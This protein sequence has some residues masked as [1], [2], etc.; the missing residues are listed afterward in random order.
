MGFNAADVAAQGLEVVDGNAADRPAVPADADAVLIKVTINNAGANRYKSN[1]PATGGRQ[2]PAELRLMDPRTGQQ[3]TSWGAQD[4]CVYEPD[5]PTTAESPDGCLDSGLIFGGAFPWE[6]SLLALSD[7]AAAESWSMTPSLASIQSAMREIA[8][9]SK[10]VISIYFRNPYILDEASGVTDAGALL[11]TFGVSDRAQLDVITG[12]AEPRGRL[13]F[14][15][16]KSRES[17]L[18]QHPDAP[19]Y[20]E[21][22]DGAL[23]RFGH[24]LGYAP[25]SGG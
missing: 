22:K 12:K 16:P 18:T 10:V 17:V 15:L 14:A 6:S 25:S 2:L 9:P 8:D 3:Q 23:F 4:P 11:A 13:P 5:A 24:G 1:D 7:I 19:G 21:T 20:D